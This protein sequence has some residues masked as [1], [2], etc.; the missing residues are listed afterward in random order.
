MSHS[1]LV[2]NR[3]RRISSRASERMDHQ[4][5]PISSLGFAPRTTNALTRAGIHSV[6]DVLSWTARDLRT[7]PQ[8]GPASMAALE[9][10]L[11][12]MG[13]SLAEP[14]LVFGR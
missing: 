6:S 13:L 9:A 2:Q 14:E 5:R 1:A 10:A 8:F 7:I 11:L 4:I 12:S 3:Y